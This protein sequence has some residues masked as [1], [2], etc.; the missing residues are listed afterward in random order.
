MHTK[1]HMNFKSMGY[2]Q[3]QVV[4]FPLFIFYMSLIIP[5]AQNRWEV[6]DFQYNQ[7]S[8]RWFKKFFFMN[9]S[10]TNFLF[11]WHREETTSTKWQKKSQQE[12]HVRAEA[13]PQEVKR[14]RQ[15]RGGT[16][17]ESVDV[18]CG[19]PNMSLPS[20][21][22]LKQGGIWGCS[23]FWEQCIHMRTVPHTNIKLMCYS[24]SC[25]ASC[26]HWA[27][28]NRKCSPYTSLVQKG[29][30]HQQK[31]ALSKALNLRL[32]QECVMKTLGICA[33]SA[34][35]QDT[36]PADTC[37]FTNTFLCFMKKE[38]EIRSKERLIKSSTQCCL[39]INV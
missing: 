14:A 16:I 9:Q 38:A 3:V 11:Q 1:G 10:G 25:Q 19:G 32:L 22:Q 7:N 13:R 36:S 33:R 29:E 15:R 18:C 2:N 37:W 24:A 26:S 23:A 17:T 28:P 12:K 20:S 30:G 8:S 39:K 6:E 31:A 27:K 34:H 5:S 21:T 4:W 35:V